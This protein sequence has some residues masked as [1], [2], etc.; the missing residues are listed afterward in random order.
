MTG[1]SRGIGRATALTFAREGSHVIVNFIDSKEKP[2]EVVEQITKMGRKAIAIKA[3]IANRDEVFKMIE[4]GARELGQIDVLVN[5]AAAVWRTPS[6]L[7][8]T[9]EEWDRV[10]GVNLLGT[11]YCVQ[12]VAPNMIKR[13]Y[14]KIVNISSNASIGTVS[15]G[16]VAYAPS[17]AGVN[18]LT[19]KLAHELGP[20]NI[21]VN[22]IAPGA[23]KTEILDII[24]PEE[25]LK[26]FLEE[27]A[28][29]A[30]LR[31]LGEPQ[32]VAN[33]ALFLASDESRFIT[34][35]VIVVDGGRFDYI[36][37]SL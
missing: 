1:A 18:I 2:E 9:K 37:H 15:L 17:K 33:L 16:Q 32:D 24:F 20:Y 3:D 34:G 35:Q 5:N 25:Q 14:G 11:Y 8:A 7:E 6:I 36:T 28:N 31:T 26:K 30:A 27:K 19:K 4:V 22:A 10:L 21:N 12:A 23:I 13:R 29:L